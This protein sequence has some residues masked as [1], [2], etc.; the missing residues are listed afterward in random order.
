MR[1]KNPLILLIRCYD[2]RAWLVWVGAAALLT[3]RLHN[4]FYLLI[5]LLVV[6]V[7]TA[8]GARPAASPRL[9]YWR[10]GLVLLT[11][12]TLL[13]VLSLHIGETVLF[14][15]PAAWP[16]VGGMMTLEAAVYGAINGL[17]LF[18][19]LTVFTAL[20]ALVPVYDLVRLTP[21]ALRDVGL[22]VLMAMT[23]VPETVRQWQG[24][25]EAQA[26][27]GHQLRGLRDWRP[28]IIPLL[29]GGLERAM[30]LAEAM[31]ARGYGATRSN[32]HPFLTRLGLG[33]GLAAGLA[34]W[35]LT[36]WLGW[37]GWILLAAGVG[38][39]LGLLWWN[40]RRVPR[41]VYK[42]HR[43]QTADTFLLLIALAPVLFLLRPL[44]FLDHSTLFY[45]PF[46]R[47]SW[48][49]A[50]P[51]V[52]LLLTSLA[53]PALFTGRAVETTPTPY[54][55][56]RR[57][58][59]PPQP[60]TFNL[61]PSPL[62]YVSHL[63]YCYPGVARPA[64]ADVSFTVAAGEFILLTGAS[65]AGKSTLLRCL[66]GLVPHF[67]GGAISG[68]VW[69]NGLDVVKEGPAAASQLAGFVWQN[70]ESQA[71]LEHVEEE[72]AFGLENAAVPPAE[73]AARVEEVL[74]QLNLIQ[75]RHRPLITLSGGERQRVAIAT[76][77][78]LR[79]PVLLLDEPTSQLDPQAAEE[80]L[81]ALARLNRDL[82][83]TILL[84]EHR[85]E[86]VAGYAGRIIHVDDGRILVDA[87]AHEAMAHLPH[88][89]PLAQLGLA[90]GWRP[91]PLS[92]AE[93]RRFVNG[94][95]HP[96][97]LSLA[98]SRGAGEQRSRGGE[99]S[100]LP[101]SPIPP[102]PRPLTLL[103]DV[104]DLHFAYDG[105]L[106][107]RGVNLSVA[108]GEVVALLG[109]NGAGKSTLF[110]CLMGLLTPTTG[111][112]Q[113][114]G[115]PTAGRDVA[116]ISQQVAYLP[117]NP[118]DLLFAETVLEELTVTLRNHHLGE[119]DVPVRPA[120]LLRELGLAEAAGRYPRDLSVGQ[121]QRVALGA[122]MVTGPKL[123]LLD[124]PTRGL[125][126][127]AKEELLTLCRRWR[128]AGTG[129]LLA[130]HDVELAAR[131][132]DRVLILT[133]GEV[134]AAGP[135]ATVLGNSSHFATDVA[136]LFPGRG[137]L[138]AED[139]LARPAH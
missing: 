122:V 2:A 9:P 131:L 14:H 72:I 137:W 94:H 45:S 84:S 121:R 70:P 71:I 77:L 66:N 111:E 43:W 5:L 91:L 133:E 123:L 62:I 37:P 3:L 10:L 74:Q 47:L 96:R 138:T 136:R 31:V 42:A 80:L 63:T 129:V 55:A 36:F 89:P 13:N 64:L 30:N 101:R 60:S 83:L 59:H 120:E 23:Y 105:R 61:Q 32:D 4:P 119:I 46:P 139:V 7:V 15:L 24:I 56:G 44:P 107:L 51:L 118:D 128:A 21:R 92:V 41:T 109:H 95:P 12:S 68:R 124:E 93:A 113:L 135:T 25:R 134:A 114:A 49:A 98:G 90:W 65:G 8:V 127:L 67:T 86:R 99:S 125:D 19:L 108:A 88:R 54:E 40:G 78:A 38:G 28:V 35:L 27:R 115:R 50:D 97:P 106:V 73:M 20:N 53:L 102:L 57:R 1:E 132:A 22:V 58:L 103:L 85:L 16:L 17:V 18:T 87:P 34:G 39:L 130:T 26:I 75:L 116:E 82:G 110:K 79:P 100:L 81:H 126:W 48:P 29:V 33:L 6:R 69:V 76:A 52:A 117:Q 11:F 104:R 112:A